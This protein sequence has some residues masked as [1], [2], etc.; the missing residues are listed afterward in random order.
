MN[1]KSIVLVFMLG[2]FSLEASAGRV[3]FWPKFS[4]SIESKASGTT[5]AESSSMTF[6]GEGAAG[7][8]FDSGFSLGLNYMLEISNDAPM[9]AASSTYDYEY[10]NGRSALGVS[11]GY[12]GANPGF[13]L[14][15]TYYLS[16]TFTQE[17]IYTSTTLNT[18][19]TTE[20]SGSGYGAQ[21]GYKLSLNNAFITLGLEYRNF[22]YDES[23]VSSGT[24][25]TLSPEEKH[26]YVLP[27][28]GVILLI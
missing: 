12:N 19:V 24:P 10:D 20:F 13:F 16:S 28:V 7:W 17:Y 21:V 23:Q 25:S 2:T 11:F 22:S 8:V 4:I 1:V 26:S 27:F 9:L 5:G 14:L 15:G 6:A 18:T 3:F